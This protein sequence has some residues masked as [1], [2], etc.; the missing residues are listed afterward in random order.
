MAKLVGAFIAYKLIKQLATPW[1]EWEAFKLGLI[2]KNGK[3]LKKAKTKEEKDAMDYSFRLVKN[4]KKLIERIPFGRTR[5]GT[6]AAAVFLL[7][8]DLGVIDDQ[9]FDIE[10][11][12]YINI[13]N[14][15]IIEGVDETTIPDG[16]YVNEETGSMYH[17]TNLE[18]YAIE[19]NVPLYRVRDIESRKYDIVSED[20][21]RKV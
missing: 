11:R 2:D 1:E 3:T 5:L 9:N 19:L 17:L 16:M 13:P 7:K 6:L 12:K 14:T 18:P 4:I 21:I 8:E 10:F 15:M 20:D